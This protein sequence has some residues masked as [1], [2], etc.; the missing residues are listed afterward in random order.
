MQCQSM[1]CYVQAHSHIR[2]QLTRNF[3]EVSVLRA[4]SLLL[5]LCICTNT[6]WARSRLVFVCV[7][8]TRVS[9]ILQ[10]IL[11]IV[12]IITNHFVF[13]CLPEEANVSL[14][15]FTTSENRNNVFRAFSFSCR[16]YPHFFLLSIVHI[17]K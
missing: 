15:T 4:Y 2:A 16:S 12:T 8:G 14:S 13:L 10:D 1:L 3:A 9:N 5:A 7:F 17:K 11:D 6:L